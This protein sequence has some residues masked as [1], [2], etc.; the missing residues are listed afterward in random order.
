MKYDFTTCFSIVDDFPNNNDEPII[1]ALHCSLRNQPQVVVTLLMGPSNVSAKFYYSATR[2]KTWQWLH[3]MLLGQTNSLVSNGRGC[4]KNMILPLEL[5]L[6]NYEIQ[7]VLCLG[8]CRLTYWDGGNTTA[9]LQT[10]FQIHF[11]E[12]NL[13][14]FYSFI[15]IWIW[16][17]NWQYAMMTN[18]WKAIIHH[19]VSNSRHISVAN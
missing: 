12:W 2:W 9:V 13:S 1:E 11:L 3:E 5:I 17:S 18:R 16:W 7:V 10:I 15:Y 19:Q 6:I 4:S 14:N 8:Q